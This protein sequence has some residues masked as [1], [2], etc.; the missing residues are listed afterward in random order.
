MYFFA[1]LTTNLRFAATILSFARWPALSLFLICDEVK[2]NFS[3]NSSVE[4]LLSVNSINSSS[5]LSTCIYSCTCLPNVIS[6]S[7]DNNGT[8]PISL[9]YDLTKSKSLLDFKDEMVDNLFSTDVSGDI[10]E[11]VVL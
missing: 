3:A 2:F 10:K 8:L 1:T 9:K 6:C 7:C 5:A 11:N 4:G